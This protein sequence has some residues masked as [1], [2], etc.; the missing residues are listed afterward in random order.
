MATVKR[1]V[2]YRIA[3]D[4]LNPGAGAGQGAVALGY[5]YVPVNDD[6]AQGDHPQ[7]QAGQ[8][9]QL[10][11]RRRQERK[12]PGKIAGKKSG[13]TVWYLYRAKQSGRL[14]IDLSGSKF[15]TLLGVYTGSKVKKL[16]KVAADDN[17]GK[18]KSSRV[19][20]RISKG[21]TYRIAGRRREGRR[22]QLPDQL[23]PVATVAGRAGRRSAQRTARRLARRNVVRIAG[24]SAAM[25]TAVVMARP[26]S[27]LPVEVS[28]V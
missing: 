10:Q 28:S 21:Q 3:V 18:G 6:L 13:Q 12:E 26:V 17:G 20:F 22:R 15:N 16:H 1:G 2:T 11:H 27:K 8:E 23:A 5:L 19:S 4:G 24:P 14:T 9:G 25:A 7:G